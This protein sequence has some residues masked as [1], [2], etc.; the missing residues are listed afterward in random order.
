MRRRRSEPAGLGAAAVDLLSCG[1]AA[2]VVLWMLV[3]PNSGHTGTGSRERINGIVRLSQYG[4][5]HLHSSTA[6]R[7][8]FPGEPAYE[9]TETDVKRLIDD[10]GKAVRPS[11]AHQDPRTMGSAQLGTVTVSAATPEGFAAELVVTLTAVRPGTRVE[12][13]FDMC[14]ADDVPHLISYLVS[15]YRGPVTGLMTW[16][17]SSHLDKVFEEAHKTREKQLD[18]PATARHLSSGGQWVSALAAKLR[19]SGA[20]T[21][22]TS[23]NLALYRFESEPRH[24]P[25]TIAA[26]STG[27]IR[28]SAASAKEMTGRPLDSD[29]LTGLR[30]WTDAVLHSPRP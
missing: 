26:T 8:H 7:V 11:V 29:F 30:N 25:L 28:L 4:A 3:V 10:A 1:L 23:R 5:A 21:S 12:L 27:L 20:A 2:A 22:S 6:V 14:W 16:Q 9:L 17:G 24:R 18:N 15:D 13:D 19:S